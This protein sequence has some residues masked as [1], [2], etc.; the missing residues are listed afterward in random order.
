M[1]NLQF[2]DIFKMIRILKKAG[3]SKQA[4]TVMLKAAEK[5][6][7]VKEGEEKAAINPK[8]LGM[9]FIFSIIENL[10]DAEDEVY[11]FFADL[12]GQSLEDIKKK[13]LDELVG[14]INDF[15]QIP[16]LNSFFSKVF[17]LMK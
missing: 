14:M 10:G 11:V 15:L 3:L 4:R 16:N 8:D 1:R 17:Q 2:Q 6:T 13:E 12:T 7:E 5:M 9:D